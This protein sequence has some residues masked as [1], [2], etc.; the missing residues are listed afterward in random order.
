MDQQKVSMSMKAEDDA[1]ERDAMKE[2]LKHTFKS[3]AKLA[4]KNIVATVL[5]IAYSILGGFAYASLEQPNERSTCFANQAI[6]GGMENA[7]AKALWEISRSL[8][9]ADNEEALMAQ[10]NAQT[11]MFHSNVIT[12]NYG[13]TNCTALGTPGGPSY[14]W[15]F[16]GALLFSVTI[17]TTV[18]KVVVMIL[19]LLLLLLLPPPPPPLLLLQPQLEI[20]SDI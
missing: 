6:Y 10:L 8:S 9:G 3:A 17:I 5:V 1:A 14:N 7:T 15:N 12:I 11:S 16:W 19:L 4:A 2:R 18:G 13:G 20:K